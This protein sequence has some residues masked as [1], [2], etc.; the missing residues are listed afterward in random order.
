MITF[1]DI[2]QA[3]DLL[4]G[5]VQ[6]TELKRSRT[7]S[8]MTGMEVHLKLENLQTT[9]SFNIRGAYN[10]IFHLT[11]E[12]RTQGVVC[13]SAGNHAQGVARASQLLDVNSTVFMPVHT[14]PPKII[15]TRSYGA[16]VILSGMTY[17]EILG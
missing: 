17:D 14:P 7:F 16:K 1:T 11:D 12:E 8:D 9:G 4:R 5:V 13:S 6:R 10:R 15:A 2:E 3:H